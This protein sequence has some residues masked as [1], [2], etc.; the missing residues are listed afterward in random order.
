MSKLFQNDSDGVDNF[1][2]SDDVGDW[3]ILYD[4]EFNDIGITSDVGPDIEMDAILASPVHLRAS[5]LDRCYH[6]NHIENYVFKRL[7]LRETPS[8]NLKPIVRCLFAEF[9]T[10]EF[11]HLI[12]KHFNDQIPQRD[13]F[14]RQTIG[15]FISTPDEDLLVGMIFAEIYGPE[16]N[17]AA[18]RNRI[19]FEVWENPNVAE[20]F[21]QYASDIFT[22]S[23]M[24]FL[25]LM[26]N[27]G[28]LT[29]HMDLSGLNMTPEIAFKWNS[30]LRDA[31]DAGV[32]L[33]Q[34]DDSGELVTRFHQ[35]LQTS[36]KPRRDF[37]RIPLLHGDSLISL[38]EQTSMK[39]SRL[40]KGFTKASF[41]ISLTTS[42][43]KRDKNALVA[44]LSHK[45]KQYQQTGRCHCRKYGCNE[46]LDCELRLFAQSVHTKSKIG[47]PIQFVKFSDSTPCDVF[48]QAVIEMVQF[49]Y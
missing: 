35:W 17:H 24:G 36:E 10:F 2:H 14:R 48:T 16:S 5:N 30:F 33:D 40:Q 28:Y 37:Q 41:W 26:G 49:K 6:S 32:I 18:N 3:S 47:D 19:F 39:Q 8:Y 7:Y 45:N 44:V 13:H 9:C 31:V 15:V 25:F 23:V 21:Q 38:V 1:G 34:R 20:A 27:C 43:K 29:A 22:Y 4:L 11:P 46:L 42:C 12:M